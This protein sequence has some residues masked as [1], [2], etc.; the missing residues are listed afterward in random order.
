[1][2]PKGKVARRHLS[3]SCIAPCPLSD[4]DVNFANT[5]RVKVGQGDVI[6]CCTSKCKRAR[7]LKTVQQLAICCLAWPLLHGLGSEG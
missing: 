6:T 3:C 7:A 5:F 1:M 4:L 2:G